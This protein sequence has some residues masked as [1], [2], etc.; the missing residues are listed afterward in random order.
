MRVSRAL[1]KLHSHLNRRG[2]TLAAGALATGLAAEATTA[3][4]A[5]LAGSIA[6]KALT[7]VVLGGGGSSALIELL[8]MT[9][10]KVA[11]AGAVFL[12]TIATLLLA[13]H[14]AQSKAAL[15]TL[16]QQNAALGEQLGQIP[17]W[18][19]Q[20]DVQPEA[21]ASV[22][23]RLR[24][25]QNE[26]PRLRGEVNRLRQQV[27]SAQSNQSVPTAG[28]SNAPTNVI[29]GF[30]R[31]QASVHSRL[32]P[33]QTL[34]MGGW[35]GH[36]GARVLLSV[37][38]EIIG[39]KGD[40]VGLGFG[41]MELPERIVAALGLEGV[42]TESTSS[43]LSVVLTAE[44]DK[45]LEET[46]WK[47]RDERGVPVPVPRDQADPASKHLHCFPN[48][49]TA[50]TGQTTGLECFMAS[51]GNGGYH[52]GYNW[53]YRGNIMVDLRHE[54]WPE[55]GLP[56]ETRVFDLG[57][58]SG[59]LFTVTPV[60]LSDAKSLDLTLQATVFWHLGDSP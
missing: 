2:V 53:K 35:P 36:R 48:Y 19:A 41:A 57:P 17:G 59:P 37:V 58:Y 13:Q 40:Q 33:G 25:A 30:T 12:A 14:Q 60:V 54:G 47:G 7:T 6:G 22:L 16:R 23:D 46:F 28:E 9:K 8:T 55:A 10:L 18:E 29:S 21:D 50:P 39:E 31:L 5:G 3:A 4:P 1:E 34:V 42:R 20:E 44:Q 49:V 56:A 32:A 11:I 27:A 43:G 51:Y 52:G 15:A 24:Q 38:P 45:A 26:L